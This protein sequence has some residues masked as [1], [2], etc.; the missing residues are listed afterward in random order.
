MKPKETMLNTMGI[1]LARASFEEIGDEHV[2]SSLQTPLRDDA[3]EMDD[4]L[5][6]ELIEKHFKDIMH[7]L[8]LDLSELRK[9]L[10]DSIQ[11]ISRFRN[12]LKIS[13]STRR[14]WWKRILP[15]ILIASIILCPFMAKRMWP[16]F[17]MEM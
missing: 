8:G 11:K 7:I 3:F 6:V 2:G 10:Q 4:D 1:D 16:T 15:S 5:K 14:C 9:Y 13:T 17:P 12:Y